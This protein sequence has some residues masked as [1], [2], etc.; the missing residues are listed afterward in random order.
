M[1]G[2]GDKS[3]IQK[4]KEFVVDESIGPIVTEMMRIFPES[5]VIVSGIFAL[6]TISFPFGILF[7]SLIEAT[8]IFH[9]MRYVTSYLNIIPITDTGAASF[10]NICR[11][12]FT[13]TNMNP[14]LSSISQFGSW[15]T[16][17]LNPFPSPPIYML[18]VASAYLFS[19]LNAQSKELEALGPAYS[20]RYYT[21]MIFLTILIFL[22]V[23]F[24]ITYSC[25]SFAVSIMSTLF[26]LFIGMLLVQQNKRLFGAESINLVGIPLLANR[27]ANGR[28]IYVCPK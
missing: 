7:G 18:S 22:F 16:G 21:S 24:R 3:L 15:T 1:P 6:I 8:A 13:D 26:G 17:S 28:P 19:T 11:T 4:T 25:D 10:R 2:T 5:L 12:G 27:T 9:A 14:S 20:S 23:C